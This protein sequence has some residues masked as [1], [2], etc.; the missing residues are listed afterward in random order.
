MRTLQYSIVALAIALVPTG[1]EA[2]RESRPGPRPH[3]GGGHIGGGHGGG[4]M[5]P[6]VGRPHVGGGHVGRPHVGR[7][8]GGGGHVRWGGRH[9]GRWVGGWQ[10][11]GGWNG[12]RRP[13]R[14][15]TLPSYW[16][17]PSFYIPNWS[18]YGFAQP[19]TGY[20]WSRY[21]DDAVLTD[22]YG[23]VYDYRENYD[24]DRYES[25]YSGDDYS[26]SYGYDEGEARDGRRDRDRRRSRDRD[27]GLGGAVIGG[28]V[29]A[30]AGSAIA[31]RGNRTAGALIGG[32]VGAL[33]GMAVDL[34]DRAG[35]GRSRDAAPSGRIYEEGDPRGNGAIYR[36]DAVTHGGGWSG[37]D[38]Y[39]PAVGSG[40]PAPHWGGGHANGGHH[41]GNVR[42]ERRVIAPHPMPASGYGAHGYGYGYAPAT[43]VVT[44]HSAPVVLSTT[45]TT[46][47]Y[48][49]EYV[50]SSRKRVWRKPAKKTWKP[51]PRCVC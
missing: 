42:V 7:P 41:G 2:G 4:V 46:T 29:G 38:D 37:P 12:Y 40:G 27:G 30:V 44:I 36:D 35:R 34:A 51:K 21:Y 26:D 23:R 17:S 14:G 49:T 24:W 9:Q 3:V 5:R 50:S 10:A 45:T 11:P 18:F 25:G 33:G 31:G 8:H 43:T 48:V 20:G 32:G 19:Q 22:R 13:H 6:P 1:A 28:A 16:I 39:G 15:Y 47:E